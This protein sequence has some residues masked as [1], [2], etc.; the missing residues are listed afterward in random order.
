MEIGVMGWMSISPYMTLF[1]PFDY[2]VSWL[3]SRPWGEAMGNF[4][5]FRGNRSGVRIAADAAALWRVRR[6]TKRWWRPNGRWWPIGSTNLKDWTRPVRA[7]GWAK[8]TGRVHVLM[9]W[10][11]EVDY[12]DRVLSVR[13][14]NT[15][16]PQ[17]THTG[18]SHASDVNSS[19]SVTDTHHESR[20]WKFHGPF[21]PH[22]RA[23]FS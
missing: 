2:E 10:R 14:I 1:N 20:Y 18:S 19:G 21:L 6:C 7:I 16:L 11:C 4:S 5:F 23:N 12:C 13:R 15:S 17:H 3:F 22:Q 9:R 8:G